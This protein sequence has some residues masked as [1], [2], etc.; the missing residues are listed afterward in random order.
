MEALNTKSAFLKPKAMKFCQNGKIRHWHLVE[1][2]NVVAGI[3]YDTNKK[4]FLLVKQFRPAVYYNKY[5]RYNNMNDLSSSEAEK[6]GCTY[7]LCAGLLDKPK[8]TAKETMKEEFL[9]ELGYDVPL[10]CI[11]QIS[12]YTMHT[13]LIG[14]KCTIFIAFINDSMKSSIH[15]GGGIDDENIEMCW[16]SLNKSRKFVMD[17]TK[18]IPP[19]IIT[20]H[21][22]AF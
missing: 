21:L 17:D 15:K 4:S 10:D 8:L 5:L 18:H 1:A 12:D 9:E 13:G 11:K 3:A 16:I 14:N 19:V 2:H 20:P 7:E 22:I 6:F